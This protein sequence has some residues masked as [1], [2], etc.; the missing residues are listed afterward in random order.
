MIEKNENIITQKFKRK[1]II[2]DRYINTLYNRNLYD[3]VFHCYFSF[4]Y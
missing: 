2:N 3:G 1:P 4:Y